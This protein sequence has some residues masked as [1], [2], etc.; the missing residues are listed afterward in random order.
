MVEKDGWQFARQSG[1][2]RHFKHPTKQGIVTIAGRSNDDIPKGT[3]A[4]ILRQA[5]ITRRGS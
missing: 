2:H 5:G 1:S 4:S 3:L